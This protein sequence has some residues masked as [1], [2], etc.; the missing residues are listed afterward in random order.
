MSA[1][2]F[3]FSFLWKNLV[4]ICIRS[5]LFSF[6]TWICAMLMKQGQR[7]YCVVG[8]TAACSVESMMMKANCHD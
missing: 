2:C 6:H 5:S 3:F 7:H 1:K 4:C 8:S